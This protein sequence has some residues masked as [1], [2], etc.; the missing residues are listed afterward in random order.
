MPSHMRVCLPNFCDADF[1]TIATAC[2]NALDR[3]RRGAVEKQVFLVHVSLMTWIADRKQLNLYRYDLNSS[4]RLLSC[5][6][7]TCCF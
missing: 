7:F 2:A 6:V 5:L 1:S 3:L 4:C